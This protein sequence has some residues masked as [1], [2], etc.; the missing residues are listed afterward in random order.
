MPQPPLSDDECRIR[1]ALLDPS[2]K[3]ADRTVEALADRLSSRKHVLRRR[4]EALARCDPPLAY[5][6]TE[7]DQPFPF[8]CTTPWTGDASADDC[9]ESL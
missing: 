5:V 1:D 7:G 9:P 8:W 6:E 2:I 3:P 4:L